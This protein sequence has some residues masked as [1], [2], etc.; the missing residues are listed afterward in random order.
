VSGTW[1]FALLQQSEQIKKGRS[2]ELCAKPRTRVGGETG[3]LDRNAKAHEVP[4]GH[5]DMAGT[6]G[7][8]ADR[9]DGEASAEQRMSRIG[10]FDLV[11]GWI[12]RVV[13]PGIVLLSRLTPSITGGC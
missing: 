9:H 1:G 3:S 4:I 12:R 8:M 2:G 13:E 6:L 7:R 11:G 10:Y 5:K